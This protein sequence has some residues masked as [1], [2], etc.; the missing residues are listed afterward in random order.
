MKPR[1]TDVASHSTQRNGD[2]YYDGVPF[3]TQCEIGLG[4]NYTYSFQ[5]ND[6]P[7]T[8]FYHGHQQAQRG[9][10]LSG[11]LIIEPADG[12]VPLHA[13]D[14]EYIVM[15]QDWY[16]EPGGGCM[17]LN[18]KTLRTLKEAGSDAQLAKTKS[19]AVSSR[20]T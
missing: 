19:C 2:L 10:G 8:Y 3:V 17:G 18:P 14:T 1:L 16:H 6:S 9:D 11:P 13:F 15:I 12:E 20:A 5:V 4:E 7:G